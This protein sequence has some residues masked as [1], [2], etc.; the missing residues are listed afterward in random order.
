MKGGRGG[1]EEREGRIKGMW[2]VTEGEGG[3][4]GK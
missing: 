2:N 3:G 4:D 1:K